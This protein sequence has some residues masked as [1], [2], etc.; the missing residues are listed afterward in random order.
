MEKAFGTIFQT[1]S[2]CQDEQECLDPFHPQSTED[3]P[4]AL[5]YW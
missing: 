2:Q 1:Q 3:V 5:P 4:E